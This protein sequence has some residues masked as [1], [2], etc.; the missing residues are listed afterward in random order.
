MGITEAKGAQV[1]HIG[2]RLISGL[3]IPLN[4]RLFNSLLKT[5]RYLNVVTTTLKTTLKKTRTF[6]GVVN[7]C[8]HTWA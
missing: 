1:A 7:V 2:K 6:K 4:A 3:I 8:A 5:T